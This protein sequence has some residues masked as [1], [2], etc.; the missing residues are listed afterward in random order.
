MHHVTIRATKV[1]ERT[2]IFHSLFCL[3]VRLL[4]ELMFSNNFKIL[5]LKQ[6]SCC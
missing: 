1:A 4:T 6:K 5:K 3:K 2:E